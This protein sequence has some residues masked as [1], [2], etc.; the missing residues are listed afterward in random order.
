MRSQTRGPLACRPLPPY[1]RLLQSPWSPT[2][3]RISIAPS[4]LLL[5]AS[6]SAQQPTAGT[7]T[8]GTASAARGQ[9]AR[10][11]LRIAAG[12]DSATDVP[13]IVV[14]GARPGRV[15]ALVAGSH[16]TE[17]TS[18]IALTRVAQNLDART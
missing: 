9:T 4:L 12:S 13:V 2:M 14:N 1:N 15:V 10:G 18:I 17:Y 5:A 3:R 6:L 11:V 8:V 7:V 16:G